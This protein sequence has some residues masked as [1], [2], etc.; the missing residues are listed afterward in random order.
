MVRRG[1]MKTK[2]KLIHNDILSIFHFYNRLPSAFL[3]LPASRLVT[4]LGEPTNTVQTPGY[5]L[6]SDCP[7]DELEPTFHILFCSLRSTFEKP[8]ANFCCV[9]SWWTA[10]GQ[11]PETATPVCGQRAKGVRRAT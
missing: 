4:S 6:V 7:L 10:S 3:P 8:A 11:Q 2:R 5:K 9:S 1:T